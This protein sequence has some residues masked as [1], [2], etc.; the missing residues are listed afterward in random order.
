[1]EKELEIGVIWECKQKATTTTQL[2]FFFN[3]NSFDTINP[4]GFSATYLGFRRYISPFTTIKGREIL[5]GVN[6][7]SGGAGI[8]PETG[9]TLVSD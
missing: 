3:G 6:Y 9:R 7:A 1:M 4:N 8:L 5:D 2:S